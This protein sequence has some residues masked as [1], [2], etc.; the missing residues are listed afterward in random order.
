MKPERGTAGQQLGIEAA[1]TF[2]VSG[3]KL[4]GNLSVEAPATEIDQYLTE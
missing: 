4:V 2:F 1:P 3:K